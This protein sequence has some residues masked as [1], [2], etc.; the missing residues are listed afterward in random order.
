MVRNVVGFSTIVPGR[1]VCQLADNPLPLNV[2]LTIVPAGAP[3]ERPP[4]M[5]VA[6]QRVEHAR[7]TTR[8]V[9][10]RVTTSVS[11]ALPLLKMPP[12]VRAWLPRAMT[13]VSVAL[14][15][16]KRPPPTRA[17]LLLGEG[18]RRRCQGAAVV[19]YAAA[20]AVSTLLAR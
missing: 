19:S 4:R 10:P 7:Y 18:L 3:I 5:R 12:P 11:V 6:V 20:V 17:E 2:W 16:L 14:P 15:L 13:S 8:A 9:L 1:S